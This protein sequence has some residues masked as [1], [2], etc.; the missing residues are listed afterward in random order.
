MKIERNPIIVFNNFTFNTIGDPHI[1]RVFKNNV[2]KD[3]LGIREKLI[4]KD[5][6]ALLNPTNSPDFVIG[7]GDLLDKT[8]VK[9]SDVLF[10]IKE[11]EKAAILNPK[12]KYV[13]LAGNH[14]LVKDK[15]QKSS[16]DVIYEYF[17]K[18]LIKNIYV[19]LSDSMTFQLDDNTQVCF[20]PYSPFNNLTFNI[21]L[22]KKLIAFGHWEITDFSKITGIESLNEYGVQEIIL[23]H[24]DLIVTGHEHKPNFY[25]KLKTYVTGSMQPYAHGEQ[26]ADEILY[27]THTLKKATANL[28]I[29]DKHYSNSNLRITLDSEEEP[30]K[31]ISC[32]SLSYLYNKLVN[33][34][35]VKQKVNVSE[36]EDIKEETVEESF[37]NNPLSFSTLLINRFSELK[38][39][40]ENLANY[41]QDCFLNKAYDKWS[42]EN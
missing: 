24:A 17:N 11:L 39:K 3:K 5:F 4:K 21:N 38:T 1:G 23:K 37:Q 14:D 28:A 10:V 40:D 36:T 7:M 13:M 15:T 33:K 42:Y 22:N 25:P 31:N 2:P 20:V 9:N 18:S 27:V 16:Y 8:T 19:T 29:D 35:S 30:L 12:I 26:L 6:I 41:L 32:L 34:N